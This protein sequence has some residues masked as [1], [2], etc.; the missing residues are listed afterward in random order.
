M[1]GEVTVEL[2]LPGFTGGSTVVVSAQPGL[3]H[4][5]QLATVDQA[6]TPRLVEVTFSV[7][8]AVCPDPAAHELDCDETDHDQRGDCDGTVREYVV[9]TPIVGKCAGE[10]V[11]LCASHAQMHGRHIRTAPR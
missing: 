2:S 5:V 4:T 7:R 11:R 3:R 8:G 10:R 9:Q 1:S 6:G